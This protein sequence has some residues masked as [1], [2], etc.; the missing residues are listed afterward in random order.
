MSVSSARSPKKSV[1]VEFHAKADSALSQTAYVAA[2]AALRYPVR[3]SC[4][5]IFRVR[6]G[7][8]F[9]LLGNVASAGD[10]TQA[11]KPLKPIGGGYRFYPQ[12]FAAIRQRFGYHPAAEHVYKREAVEGPHTA[13]D[14][15]YRLLIESAQLRDF[16]HCFHLG[17][18]G[19]KVWN[20]GGAGSV[21]GA[22][23]NLGA[24]GSVEAE[25]L[26]AA[27]RE[28][29]RAQEQALAYTQQYY[30]QMA[31]NPNHEA[32]G[33]W[34][35]ATAASLAATSD[36]SQEPSSGAV[37][38]SDADAP[39]RWQRENILDL[40]RE[41]QEELKESSL[42]ERALGRS[43]GAAALEEFSQLHYRYKGRYYQIAA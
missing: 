31:T 29:L 20:A 40:R 32:H 17:D 42:L 22:R 38:G 15:D 19:T 36:A 5:Y 11:A 14:Y 12:T 3:I 9:L 28:F 33:A 41:F 10:S 18:G 30:Q 7:D 27:D 1:I 34:E 16:M 26:D 8:Q 4:A 23:E 6:L 24:L 35:V 13:E 25:Q 37:G 39:E 43:V 2:S 21:W